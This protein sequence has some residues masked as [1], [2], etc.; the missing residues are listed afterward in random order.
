MES[1]SPSGPSGGA[2]PDP[3]APVSLPAELVRLLPQ[4]ACPDCRGALGQTGGGLRCGTCGADIPMHD[5]IPLFGR[6]GSVEKWGGHKPSETSESYQQNYQKLVE[7][8]KYNVMYQHWSKRMT[9]RREFQLLEQLLS[10]QGRC[11][12]LLDLP[13]GGGRLSAPLAP[14]TDLLVEADIAVGQLLYGREHGRVGTAQVWMTA[15]GFHIPFRDGGVDGVVCIRLNHHLPTAEE[16]ERLVA[17]LLRVARRFVI[18]T[19][20]DFHSLK[21]LGRRLRRPF[22]KQPPKMTMTVARVRELAQAGG[23]DLVAC[24]AISHLGSGHRYALMVKRKA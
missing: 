23:A 22:D 1:Q 24:P 19:F 8:A 20:F 3:H 2:A 4:L 9:T 14:H 13:C 11:G 6:F 21:N 5:G 10:S 15:S 18:M 16:R 12:T 17:E 7:A